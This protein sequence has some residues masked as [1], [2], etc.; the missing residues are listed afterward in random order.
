M[1]LVAQISCLLNVTLLTS[2]SFGSLPLF[3]QTLEEL[4][5]EDLKDSLQ[6]LQNSCRLNAEVFKDL[7]PEAARFFNDSCGSL[8]DED[9]ENI[10]ETSNEEGFLP[11]LL[12]RNNSRSIEVYEQALDNAR[13]VGDQAKERQ[14]L[15]TLAVSY[16]T[17]H[18]LVKA[19]KFYEDALAVAKQLNDL[20]VQG[21]TLNNI[22]Q[23][24]ARRGQYS[25]A[26][27]YLKE[28]LAITSKGS[29]RGNAT[30]QLHSLKLMALLSRYQGQMQQAVSFYEQ[31]LALSQTET[32]DKVE[33]VMALR[34]IERFYVFRGEI[35]KALEL[36][37]QILA[38]GKNDQDKA[39]GAYIQLVA[40]KSIGDI[41]EVQQDFPKAL[42]FYGKAVALAKQE[43]LS[44]YLNSSLVD[45]ARVYNRLGQY[46]EAK[47]TLLQA[48]DLGEQKD[49]S[50][51]EM[52]D[53]LNESNSSL[54]EFGLD[55]K[56]EWTDVVTDSM[57]DLVDEF[58]PHL[59]ETEKNG[60]QE[61]QRSLIAQNEIHSALEI[62]ERAKAR[63]F[64]TSVLLRFSDSEK[65]IPQSM[66]ETANLEQIKRIAQ[67][68]NATLVQ[69][70]ILKQ[71]I[72]DGV[73]EYGMTIPSTQ[74]R[75]DLQLL[76][77]VIKPSGE[78]SF[79]QVDLASIDYSVKSVV[80]TSRNAVF[81]GRMS[82]KI[83]A[84]SL[85]QLHKVLIEPIADQLPSDPNS[86]VVF[87]PDDALFLVPFP[88]LQDAE[89]RYLIEKHTIRTAP[90]IRVLELVE[91]SGQRTANQ[92]ALVVG[93][94]TM[95]F[96]SS[97]L[98]EEPQQLSNLPNA[99]LE[100]NAIADLLNTQAITGSQATKKAIV[101][102]MPQAG[103]IHLATHGLLD[104]YEGLGSAIALTPSSSDDGL[105]TANEILDMKLKAN[106]VVLSACDTGRGVITGDGVIGLSRSFMVAGVPSVVVSL[107]SVPDAPTAMLMTQFYQNL[108]QT[109]D[110][111]QAL[112]QAM[113][114]TLKEYPSPLD[115]AAFTL[116]GKAF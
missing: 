37:N 5:E 41:Y 81:R 98:G 21:E 6:L 59:N 13:K 20:Q 19:L 89:G 35:E 95:P 78:I 12:E 108:Q 36:S 62:A 22:A 33:R 18:Q 92:N 40:F 43:D 61:L 53:L 30:I 1:R 25:Q 31:A 99:E 17:S 69:Y 44:G 23:L 106:L 110:K 45:V 86:H 88:A 116:I 90:A 46:S 52:V 82:K 80:E 93:N 15:S 74:A 27:E 4:E 8:T 39:Q 91:A 50:P 34:E 66:L 54:A 7:P 3:A 77:W 49:K 94:P 47:K 83:S 113:L 26:I 103:I 16:E 115:W 76:I 10:T 70:S 104:H 72:Q 79:R 85:Q 55:I 56:P 105:L 32:I 57:N 73:L 102:Q 58:T 48:I 111:A 96:Y 87:I 63:A 14:I 84:S 2:L 114:T 60:Y 29:G 28:S 65:S 38:L 67:A 51:L 11:F 71:P 75:E 109:P 42:E 100:A 97:K 68:Q 101:E 107:W 112:R 24:Y 9:L 64:A